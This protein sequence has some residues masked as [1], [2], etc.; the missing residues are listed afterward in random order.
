MSDFI[1]RGAILVKYRGKGADVTVPYGVKMIDSDAFYG[2]KIKSVT[3]PATVREIGHGAFYN[4]GNLERVVLNEGLYSIGRWAFAGCTS[5]KE[6][7]IPKSLKKITESSFERCQSLKDEDGF[8]FIGPILIGYRGKEE[9][10]TVP[11]KTTAIGSRV[12]EQ[13]STVKKI[14]IPAKVKSIGQEAFLGCSSLEEVVLSEGLKIIGGYAFRNCV[15]LKKLQIPSTVDVIGNG[16]F[17]WCTALEKIVLPEGPKELGY[18]LSEGCK[19]LKEV[20]IPASVEEVSDNVFTG[21]NSLQTVFFAGPVN[22]SIKFLRYCPIRV[23]R[24]PKASVSDFYFFKKEYLTGFVQLLG[25]GVEIAPETVQRNNN[26]IKHSAQKLYDASDELFLYMLQNKLLPLGDIDGYMER[27]N[28]QKN[29]ARVAALLDY[30]E[31]N[32]T[33]KQKE[34]QFNRQFEIREPTLTELRQIWTFAKK[35]DGTY[36]LTKYKGKDIDVTVPSEIKGV[37]VSAVGKVGR[38]DWVRK[39]FFDGGHF[40]NVRSL[41]L[42]NGIEIIGESAFEECTSLKTVII[43][44]SVRTICKNAFENCKSLERVVLGEGLETIEKWAFYGCEALGDISVPKSVKK[45][46]ASAFGECQKLKDKDGFVIFNGMLVLY[47]GDS[48]AAILP[49]GITTIASGAFSNC[50][51]LKKVIIPETVTKIKSGAFKGCFKITVYCRSAECPPGWSK[52]WDVTL[53]DGS[54]APVVWGYKGK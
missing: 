54:R 34:R 33:Q 9:Q 32:F 39:D 8:V 48:A 42:Q 46:E 44:P 31:K 25:M 30:R 40:K 15:S 38:K 20:H 6:I 43:P 27:Y 12:F 28:A 35:K 3:L 18:A 37:R 29:V 21:C 53:R 22:Y 7:N 23:I 49:D 51:L 45:I 10:I 50:R 24:A 17:E 11:E 36:E 4:C 52:N 19:S 2:S 5:L 41:T 14:T 16:A 13:N 47:D 26:Y 1:F